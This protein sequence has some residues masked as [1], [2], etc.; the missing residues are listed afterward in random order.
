[1]SSIK[2]LSIPRS[3][4]GR[5][6]FELVSEMEIVVSIVAGYRCERNEMTVV[7]LAKL[8]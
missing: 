4:Q 3:Q 6:Q 2:K 1:M 7:L 8:N 5:N